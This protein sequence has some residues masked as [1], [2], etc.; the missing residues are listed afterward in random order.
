M[1][2]DAIDQDLGPLTWVKSEIDQAL[3]RANVALEDIKKDAGNT[4]ALSSAKTNLTQIRGALS[5]VNLE[6]LTEFSSAII[7]LL[8]AFSA[9]Q[10]RQKDKAISTAQLGIAVIGNYLEEL[11]N[12][13]PDQPLRLYQQ[14]AE[15]VNAA[16]NDHPEQPPRPTDLFF[17]DLS[18]RPPVPVKSGIEQDK[19]LPQKLHSVRAR[20]EQGML[21]W[22]QNPSNPAGASIMC[23]AISFLKELAPSPTTGALWWAAQA[24]F[25][26]LQQGSLI[27]NTDIKRVCAQM[28]REIRKLPTISLELPE[29][30]M[31]SLLYWVGQAPAKTERQ[32]AVHKLWKLDELIPEAGT[33]ITDIPLLPLLKSLH[34]ELEYVKDAWGAFC[35]GS[36]KELKTF[37]INLKELTTHAEPLGRPALHRLLRGIATFAVWIRRDPKQ[38]TPQAAMEVA[39][40]LLLCEAALDRNALEAGYNTQVNDSLSRLGSLVRGEVLPDLESS[41]TVQVGRR[42]QEKEALKQTAREIQSNLSH[43]EQ[44]LD[45]FFRNP[46][47]SDNLKSLAGPLKQIAGVFAFLGEPKTISLISQIASTVRRFTQEG[48]RPEK[49]EFETLAQQLSALGFF[50]NALQFGGSAELD[51]YLHPEKVKQ[52]QQAEAQQEL[53]QLAVFSSAFEPQQDPD[54]LLE[55]DYAH[56]KALTDEKTII[57]V[58]ASTETQAA[59]PAPVV[60]PAPLPEEPEEVLEPVATAAD[61]TAPSEVMPEPEVT[62]TAEP[63]PTTA[64]EEPVA[65]AD[66]EITESGLDAELLEIFLEEANEVLETVHDTLQSLAKEPAMEDLTTIRRSFHTLKG[67]G[68]MVGLGELGEAAWS[69]EQTLNKWLQK[70][71][72]PTP[73]LC[74]LISDAHDVFLDWVKQIQDTGTEARDVTALVAH[75]E[76]LRDITSPSAI[77]DVSEESAESAEFLLS[78]ELPQPVSALDQ[79]MT[80]EKVMEMTRDETRAE[81]EFLNEA[82]EPETTDATAPMPEPETVAETDS[83]TALAESGIEVTE[84]ADISDEELQALQNQFNEIAPSEE[85]IAAEETIPLP[86]TETLEIAEQPE[87]IESQQPESLLD[88]T[89]QFESTEDILPAPANTSAVQEAP[90][91]QQPVEIPELPA[92]P[93][94]TA[95]PETATTDED[96]PGTTVPSE[97]TEE[98]FAINVH[99]GEAEMSKTLFG[100]YVDEARQHLSNLSDGF[101]ELAANPQMVPSERTL[102]SAHTLAGISGTASIVPLHDLAKA[103]ENALNLMRTYSLTPT[104][105]Q[106]TLFVTVHGALSDML[107]MVTRFIMP[108]GREDLEQQL[109]QILL[110]ATTLKDKIQPPAPETQKN[111]NLS[112]LMAQVAKSASKAAANFSLIEKE[113]EK[114]ASKSTVQDAIDEQLLPIFLEES[115]EQIP[116]LRGQLRELQAQPENE[117]QHNAIARLLHTMKG[118]ARMAGAM[119]LG[120]LIHNLETRLQDTVKGDFNTA[121]LLAELEDGVDQIEEKIEYLRAGPPSEQLETQT[122]DTGETAAHK[123]AETVELADTSAINATLRIRADLVDRFVNEAGEIGIS[124]TRIEDELK[125]ARRALT[126]LTENVIRLRNQLRE[127]EIQA[128]VQMQSR[129]AQAETLQKQFDPLE[130]DRFTRLQELTRMMAEGVSDVTTVQQ[131]LLKSLDEADMALQNQ[132]RLSRDLQQSLMQVRMVPFDSLADRLHRVVRQSAKDLGK[133]VN[134]DIRGGNIEIDRSVLEHITAPL[135]HILRNAVSHGIESR[136]ERQKYGKNEIGQIT[137]SVSHEGNE[138]SIVLTDDGQGLDYEAIARKARERGLLEKD[139]QADE[140]RLS[141]MIFLPGFSTSNNLS[142][143][144]GRG[145]GMDVV[146]SETAAVGGRVDI[147]STRYHGTEFNIRLPLTLAVTQAVLVQAGNKTYAIPSSMITQVME[148]RA[149][150]LETARKEGIVK[151]Q[152]TQYAYHYLPNLLGNFQ[153]APEIQRFNW[154]MLLRSGTQSLALHVDQLKGNQEIVIKNAGPQLVRIVGISGVTILGNGDIV[155]IINPVALASRRVSLEHMPTGISST[156]KPPPKAIQQPLVMIVDDSLTV[157]KITGR[158]LEREGYKVMTAKDGNDA[159]EKLIDT[160]PDVIL[161]DIEMPRMDGFELLRNIRANT[162][163]K[164]VPVIMITSRLAERHKEYAREIGANNYLG[165]PFDEEELLELLKEYTHHQIEH[166]EN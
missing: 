27:V 156:S 40:A 114:P 35:L 38:C 134:L 37:A 130:M 120:E 166:V 21:R 9:G 132:A 77:S 71:W 15:I 153:A 49:K 78:S 119:L 143:V 115:E 144:S 50:V 28:H 81:P 160:I 67:S 146:R 11:V 44:T 31:C 70:E 139:E 131:N 83:T 61:S 20:F 16:C 136:E 116:Q 127:V 104:N 24:F 147:A 66:E 112:D 8:D 22:L 103:L 51:D 7:A 135:E 39:C 161:S 106:Q 13:T 26:T 75:S 165:K 59:E 53:R 29:K 98:S 158:L 108:S 126:D 65:T 105:E 76:R 100:L 164:D 118:G 34:T 57:P 32:L 128:E 72:V 17:P 110:D 111:T 159:L 30:L 92:Q 74:A 141:N 47:Q 122:S 137:L 148:L 129:M 124:R 62:A 25:D 96:L 99:I 58:P 138:I 60:I 69:I 88:L 52:R 107:N 43:V 55:A 2:Q 14:Y 85:D 84:G 142:I 1:K 68:R 125:T 89:S 48:P 80:A 64:V 140:V 123:A 45:D 36:E 23:E 149:P 150:E 33:G 101:A 162:A 154:V 95:Q 91:S 6:G 163:T 155:L 151:W 56:S 73:A 113:K 54:R 109:K 46:A 94:E 93:E 10:I 90:V 12:G 87:V 117:S 18:V 42:R 19:D 79:L 63:E 145:V 5:V 121:E 157:R 133:R 97:D 82:P 41:D 3:G 4:G 102:R 152:D 86:E